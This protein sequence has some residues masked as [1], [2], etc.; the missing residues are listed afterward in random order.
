MTGELAND[1]VVRARGFRS[2]SGGRSGKSSVRELA[3]GLNLG[4]CKDR[5]YAG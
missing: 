1:F 3:E 5:V 2:A 4:I